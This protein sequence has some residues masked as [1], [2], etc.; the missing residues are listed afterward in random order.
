[1]ATMLDRLRQVL[2]GDA[3]PAPVATLIGF[4]LR[5]VERGRAVI[6]LEADARDANPMGTLHGGVLCDIADA[7]MGVAYASTLDEGETFATVELKINFSSRCGRES[8]RPRAV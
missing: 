2:S 6:D 5:E 4:T 1:M 8:S 7:A 3:P